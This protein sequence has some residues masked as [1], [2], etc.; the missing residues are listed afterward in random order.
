LIVDEVAGWWEKISVSEEVWRTDHGQ[1][2]TEKKGEKG[3]S[4]ELGKESSHNMAARGYTT[5]LLLQH[6]LLLLQTSGHHLAR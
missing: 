4:A 2:R 6:L 1:D 5:N 3:E